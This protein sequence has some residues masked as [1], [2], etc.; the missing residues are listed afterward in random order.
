MTISGRDRTSREIKSTPRKSSPA[1][2]YTQGTT[3]HKYFQAALNLGKGRRTLRIR[4]HRPLLAEVQEGGSHGK[5]SSL[6]TAPDRGPRIV[7]LQRPWRDVSRLARH[8]CR[9]GKLYPSGFF[10]CPNSEVYLRQMNRTKSNL[11]LCLWET[12]KDMGSPKVRQLGVLYGGVP[13]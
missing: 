12:P 2:I 11:I 4:F 7:R 5:K 3:S 8:N 13:S 9:E 10:S 6:L 1:T